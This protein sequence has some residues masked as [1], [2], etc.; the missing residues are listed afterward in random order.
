MERAW[1]V[2]PA[3][4]HAWP[5][6]VAERARLPDRAG[7]YAWYFDRDAIPAIVP[8]EGAQAVGSRVLLYVGIAPGGPAPAHAPPARS[9]LRTRLRTHFAGTARR[10]TLRL[11]LGC[12]LAERLALRAVLDGSEAA[13][14]AWL[15]EHA[16]VAWLEH[17]EPWTVELDAIRHVDLPLNLQHNRDHRF[18]A[19]LSRARRD[20]K[21]GAAG[22]DT[23]RRT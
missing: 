14:S 21:A 5:E 10:S 6:L 15:A 1:L 9:N 8:C 17:A 4:L 2:A 18:H 20:A 13:L 16:R 12:L 23:L 22:C 3:R 7:V 11:S 19:V